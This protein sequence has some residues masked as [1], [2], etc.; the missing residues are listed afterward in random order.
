MKYLAEIRA[1]DKKIVQFKGKYNQDVHEQIKTSFQ[2]VLKSS[3][4]LAESQ[5]P[6]ETSA[7]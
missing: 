5:K 1:F 4:E 2:T 7:T 6:N 3:I